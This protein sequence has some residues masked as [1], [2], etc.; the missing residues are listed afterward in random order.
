L[1]FRHGSALAARFDKDDL[2]GKAVC[3]AALQREMGLP[4]RPDVRFSA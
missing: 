1:E 2:A 3:K 4:Q